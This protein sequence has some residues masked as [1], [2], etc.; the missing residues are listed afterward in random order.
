MNVI[1]DIEKVTFL[2]HLTLNILEPSHSTLDVN[3]S[4]ILEPIS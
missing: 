4:V 1:L 2:N 3:C